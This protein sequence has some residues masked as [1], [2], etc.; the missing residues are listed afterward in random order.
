[1]IL[2]VRFTCP[3]AKFNCFPFSFFFFF[4]SYRVFL[5]FFFFSLFPV[6]SRCLTSSLKKI[7]LLSPLADDLLPV[8]LPLFLPLQTVNS[9]SSKTHSLLVPPG[10]KVCSIFLFPQR[11]HFLLL[12]ANAFPFFS[13]F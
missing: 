4:P 8:P 5:V 1:M 13:S 12:S 7:G 10:K 9:F 6:P 2:T 11:V 3:S